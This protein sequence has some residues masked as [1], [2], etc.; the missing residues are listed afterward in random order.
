MGGGA[1]RRKKMAAAKAKRQ[2][3]AVSKKSDVIQGGGEG[4][5]STG[6]GADAPVAAA[7]KDADA[8]SDRGF[9]ERTGPRA[10]QR[11]NMNMDFRIEN[12]MLYAGD[13]VQ[14]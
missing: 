10:A 14:L 6:E 5:P 13:S 7:A 12:I 4:A 11:Q 1:E 9:F 8:F 3:V 2:A